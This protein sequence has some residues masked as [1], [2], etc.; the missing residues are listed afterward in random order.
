M[1]K[2]NEDNWFYIPLFLNGQTSVKNNKN[3]EILYFTQHPVYRKAFTQ[4]KKEKEGE[5]ETER[6]REMRCDAMRW[7]GDSSEKKNIQQQRFVFKT[8]ENRCENEE[9]GR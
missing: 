3:L 7:A 2:L 8:K 6:G 4:R 9:L 5:L 1:S